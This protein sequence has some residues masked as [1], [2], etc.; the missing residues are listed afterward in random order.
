MI[1]AHQLGNG[2]E[3][4]A[5]HDHRGFDP[6]TEGPVLHFAVTRLNAY[7]TARKFPVSHIDL[8]RDFVLA[9][10]K[11]NGIEPPHLDKVTVE[12]LHMPATLLEAGDGSHIVA[13]G[14]HRIVKAALVGWTGSPA[15]LVP[16]TIWRRFVISGV[17]ELDQYWRERLR[18][19]Q[20]A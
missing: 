3:F 5:W 15:W 14:A 19:S 4:F 1:S 12:R 16:E 6:G 8:G 11:Q 10:V 18:A 7:L 9:V 13:D 20:I 17:G 2:E